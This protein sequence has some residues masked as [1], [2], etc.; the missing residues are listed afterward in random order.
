M[1]QAKTKGR[2]KGSAYLARLEEALRKRGETLES[3]RAN[4]VR[5]GYFNIRRD[6]YDDGWHPKPDDVTAYYEMFGDIGL[7]EKQT[8]CLCSKSD[9][10]WNYILCHKNG[11]PKTIMIVGST[12]KNQIPKKRCERCSKGHRNRKDNLCNKCRESCFKCD[13]KLGELDNNEK[14]FCGLCY[15][16]WNNT[17]H[18]KK[19]IYGLRW[20][21]KFT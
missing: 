9:I 10:A 20:S 5:L 16:V 21:S 3:W 13:K 15:A 14:H 19:K 8:T 1:A 6:E 18:C 2:G 4:Y 17:D 12:C 11:D 7:P